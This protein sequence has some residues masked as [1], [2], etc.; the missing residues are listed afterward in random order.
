MIRTRPFLTL[1]DV[2]IADAPSTD[3]STEPQALAQL[4]V[5]A[6]LT[7]EEAGG[8]SSSLRT[9]LDYSLTAGDLGVITVDGN[10]K[11]DPEAIPR[12]IDALA[13]GFDY[14]QGS[15]YIPG[16]RGLNTPRSRDLL[17]RYVHAPLFSILSGRHLTDTTNGFRA[18]SAPLVRSANPFR[19]E[20]T[21]YEVY[22][23]LAWAACRRGFRV[24]EIPVTRAYPAHGPTP[25]KIHGLGRYADMAAPLMMLALRRW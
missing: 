19:K 16:G 14:V 25:T 18:Y 3:G 24:T 13:Q 5:H 7:L 6:L 4:G 17:I 15:R 22:Y 21:R 2:L 9:A 20:F 12:F 8:M 11:D 10:D 1:V 23:Y